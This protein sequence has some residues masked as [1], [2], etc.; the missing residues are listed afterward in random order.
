MKTQTQMKMW[1]LGAALIVAG[2]AG[3]LTAESVDIH[4][5]INASKSLQ[6][7]TTAYYFGAVDI[8][9]SSHS[10]T[11][12]VVRNT[13]GALIETYK[14]S[15]GNAISD[16]VGTDWTLNTTPSQD[17][18]VLS[19]QFGT[20]R[21]A[22]ATDGNWGS[23]NLTITPTDCDDDAFG[24]GTPGQTGLDVSPLA[25]GG[26]YNRNLWFRIKTPVTATDGG[27]HTALV[28]LSVK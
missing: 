21:P 2:F 20:A 8:N 16:T 6:A 11:A 25:A 24:N 7:L 26:A 22:D 19:A 12:L 18:Y 10:A 3:S 27:A 9:N 1:F 14:L 13:S 17:N 15:A 4:V 23:D 28:T 5:S